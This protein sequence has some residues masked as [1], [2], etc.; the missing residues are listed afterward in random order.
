MAIYLGELCVGGVCESTG[1]SALC[2]WTVGRLNDS[3]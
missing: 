1:V 3:D 2:V